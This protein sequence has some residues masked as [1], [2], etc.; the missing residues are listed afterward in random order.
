MPNRVHPRNERAIADIGDQH[1]CLVLEPFLV[2]E[3]GESRLRQRH[4]RALVE[5]VF[6]EACPGELVC[7]GIYSPEFLLLN[8]WKAAPRNGSAV[9]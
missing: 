2:A 9:A 5:I 4:G 8:A 3:K 6:Q 1:L 7:V